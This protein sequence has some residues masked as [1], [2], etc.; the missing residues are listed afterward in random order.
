MLHGAGSTLFA[1]GGRATTRHTR[2][3]DRTHA[4]K[5]HLTSGHLT[6]K[7]TAA[8]LLLGS[9]SPSLAPPPA[10]HAERPGARARTRTMHPLGRRGRIRPLSPPP[11]T[12]RPTTSL[13][14]HASI[15]TCIRAPCAW[16]LDLGAY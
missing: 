7:L 3:H 5:D 13:F 8:I 2:R 10:S 16:P 14:H 11:N 9:R 6:T 15:D 1:T 4:G 12:T